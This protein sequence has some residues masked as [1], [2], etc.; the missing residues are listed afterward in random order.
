MSEKYFHV[1]RHPNDQHST[2]VAFTPINSNPIPKKYLDFKSDIESFIV[3]IDHLY[4]KDAAKKN[5]FLEQAYYADS[6]CFSGT[7]SDFSTAVQTLTEIKS[8][9]ITTSWS[10]IRNR[11]LANY[12]VVVL[13]LSIFFL[14]ISQFTNEVLKNLPI[15]L[16]GSCVG[17]WLSMA[18]R[19][20]D[21]EFDDIV[22]GFNE[23]DSPILRACFVCVLTSVIT[24]LLL[25]GFLEINIGNMSSSAISSDGWAA[26]AV[27]SIF[28]FGEK[29][30]VSTLTE[31]SQDYLN[32]DK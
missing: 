30:L 12:G 31:K 20:K 27:G 1:S 2:D 9:V 19:T 8:K 21:F 4:A 7:N 11:I 32:G 26:F 22:N 6:L 28:G 10:K 16:A 3:A 5:D 29:T 14:V 23:F 13:I 24:V 18:I 15:V 25:S 17:S